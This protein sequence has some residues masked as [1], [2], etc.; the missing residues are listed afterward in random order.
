MFIKLRILIRVCGLGASK[1]KPPK[2]SVAFRTINFSLPCF[3]YLSIP[4]VG[5][6]YRT[7]FDSGI[8]DFSMPPG[9]FYRKICSKNVADV[10]SQTSADGTLA[11]KFVIKPT[12][13]NFVLFSNY[14]QCSKR[15]NLGPKNL[16][17][18]NQ[19]L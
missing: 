8:F 18:K 19:C 15:F 1:K 5:E 11:I 7:Y 16:R 14:F 3:R 4:F 9:I 17:K 10:R 12:S 2:V 13:N 6:M